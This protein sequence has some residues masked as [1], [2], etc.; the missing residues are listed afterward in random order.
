MRL[1]RRTWIGTIVG[2]TF[3]WLRRGRLGGMIGMGGVLRGLSRK[4]RREIE[5]LGNLVCR[6]FGGSILLRSVVWK[7]NL[8]VETSGL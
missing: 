1:L 3:R 7:V 5:D 8:R 4:H 6:E 2:R